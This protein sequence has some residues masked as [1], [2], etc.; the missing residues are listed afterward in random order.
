MNCLTVLNQV[1]EIL[2]ENNNVFKRWSCNKKNGLH[3]Q[4]I[5]IV[6]KILNIISGFENNSLV[7]DILSKDDQFRLSEMKSFNVRNIYL[8]HIDYDSFPFPYQFFYHSF[9]L[10]RLKTKNT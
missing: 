8:I 6:K 3:Y 4:K 5:K 2:Q 10:R 1:F 7:K 9:I